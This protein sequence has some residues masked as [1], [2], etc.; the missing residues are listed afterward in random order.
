LVSIDDQI[1]CVTREIALRNRVYAS[2]IEKRAMTE[3]E[4][5]RELSAMQAVLHTLQTIKAFATAIVG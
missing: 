3:A 2:R 5:E 4:A 1:R